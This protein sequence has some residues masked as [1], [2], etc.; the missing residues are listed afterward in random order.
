MLLGVPAVAAD[1]GGVRNLMNRE[2]EGVIYPS[3]NVQM[4]TEGII[5]LFALEDRAAELG[6]TAGYHARKTHDPEK[7]LQDLICIYKEIC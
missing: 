2:T 6:K 4:L 7:N 1:V 5:H 3:G